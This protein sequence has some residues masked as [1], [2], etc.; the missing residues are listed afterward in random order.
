MLSLVVG[1]YV[2][3]AGLR[4]FVVEPYSVPSEAMYPTLPKGSYIIT[5]KWGYGNYKLFGFQIMKT[6]ATRKIHRGDIIVFEFPLKPEIDYIKRMVGVPGDVIQY[7]DNGA[8][9]DRVGHFHRIY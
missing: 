4:I 9:P 7:K 5:S 6:A 3:L 2:G 1:M 8:S